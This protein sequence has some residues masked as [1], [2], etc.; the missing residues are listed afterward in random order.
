ML[1]VEFTIDHPELEASIARSHAGGN[2]DAC[3]SVETFAAMLAYGA[4]LNAYETA[5]SGG[6]YTKPPTEH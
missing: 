5:T 6:I 4:M 2:L 3:P 1:R